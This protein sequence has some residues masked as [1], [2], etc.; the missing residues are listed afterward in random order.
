MHNPFMLIL[1]KAKMILGEGT[2]ATLVGFTEL[3]SRLWCRGSRRARLIG[4]TMQ[5][6]SFKMRKRVAPT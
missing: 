1:C 2:L 4:R 5:Q 6:T 3:N